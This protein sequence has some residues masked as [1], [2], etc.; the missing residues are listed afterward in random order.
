M[1]SMYYLKKIFSSFIIKFL[2]K[3]N[4]K[5]ITEKTIILFLNKASKEN[6]RIWKNLYQKNGKIEYIMRKLFILMSEN[7]K[8]LYYYNKTAMIINEQKIVTT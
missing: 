3:T 6:L 7:N 1:I 4:G 5:Y 2:K 8:R